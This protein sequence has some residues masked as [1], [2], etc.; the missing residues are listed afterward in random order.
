MLW[1]HYMVHL[2]TAHASFCLSTPHPQVPLH[3]KYDQ[4]SNHASLHNTVAHVLT[5]RLQCACARSL[6][7]TPM[8]EPPM[9][10]TCAGRPLNID[11]TTDTTT[12]VASLALC[13]M[14]AEALPALAPSWEHS[15]LSMHTPNIAALVMDGFAARGVD[16]A[17][18]P[19]VQY[20]TSALHAQLRDALCARVDHH[21]SGRIH[22]CVC[23]SVC[24]F[25][26]LAA[27]PRTQCYNTNTH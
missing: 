16:D 18:I 6:Y 20:S 15:M 3:I 19:A 11:T 4:H 27:H 9:L 14:A 10:H 23:W 2:P 12:M 25:F 17:H 21:T 24:V 8:L 22:C 26:L 5:Q 13:H 1:M 7:A